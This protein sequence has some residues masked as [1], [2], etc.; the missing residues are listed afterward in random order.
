MYMKK[1]TFVKNMFDKWSEHEFA[2]L[3]LSR[4]DIPCGGN[5]LTLRRRKNPDAEVIKEGDADS[6]QG[7]DRTHHNW[8]P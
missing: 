3:R 8:V 2:T 5:I 6:L 7:R 4:K 1:Q